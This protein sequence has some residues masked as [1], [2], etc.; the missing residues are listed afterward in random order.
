M[1]PLF[2]I[3][4]LLLS[5]PLSSSSSADELVTTNISQH[6]INRLTSLSTQNE[7]ALKKYQLGDVA[8]ALHIYQ[9]AFAP[10]TLTPIAM[11]RNYAW[12]L[13]SVN[14]EA[15]TIAARSVVQSLSLFQSLLQLEGSEI[16]MGS[17]LAQTL[18]T[19]Y[20][21]SDGSYYGNVPLE[22][23]SATKENTTA[24]PVTV[25]IKLSHVTPA[26][27]AVSISYW[28]PGNRGDGDMVLAGNHRRLSIPFRTVFDLDFKGVLCHYPLMHGA[29][30]L[31]HATDGADPLVWHHLNVLKKSV[32]GYLAGDSIVVA[33]PVWDIHFAN[34]PSLE[35]W[36]TTPSSVLTQVHVGSLNAMQEIVAEIVRTHVPG[37]V[38]EAGVFR[39]GM[40][41]FMA[42][43]LAV[44]PLP[45]HGTPPPPRTVWCADTF[46]GIPARSK[47]EASDIEIRNDVTLEWQTNA[48]SASLEQVRSNFQRYGVLKDNVGFVEGAFADTLDT[49]PIRQVALL[50]I[51]CDTYIGTMDALKALYKRMP[52]GGVVVV[53]DFHLNGARTAVLEFRS[54][55]N[56]STPIMPIPND[57]VHSC[58]AMAPWQNVARMN[59][60]LQDIVWQRGAQ[61]KMFRVL[62]PQAVYWRVE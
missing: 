4:T 11:W 43:L 34:I 57:Y 55:W 1:L 61:S 42:Q 41:I 47:A 39:G 29:P 26:V 7:L 62:G 44:L 14:F 37:D 32:T 46:R 51:D 16:P 27:V 33:Q 18:Q 56:I 52:T 24:T 6:H 17:P 12:M 35:E 38:V 19:T 8:A 2:F 58:T 53:D 22:F 54:A 13:H 20:N 15:E 21:E 49:A 31:V 45:V 23:P 25:N 28:S 9:T 10:S 36:H 30:D 3:A 59:I 40:S 5:Y 50:R 48:Y 60:F